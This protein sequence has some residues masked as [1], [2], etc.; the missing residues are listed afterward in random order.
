LTAVSRRPKSAVF[1]KTQFFPIGA[2]FIGPSRC[3]AEQA[4]GIMFALAVDLQDVIGHYILI[5]TYHVTEFGHA[6]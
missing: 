5:E 6:Q 4:K 1:E 2:N 3:P